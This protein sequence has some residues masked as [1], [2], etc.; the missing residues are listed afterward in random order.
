VQQPNIAPEVTLDVRVERSNGAD[1]LF[2]AGELDVFTAPILQREL[3]D[4]A[5]T[6]G[7]LILDLR[8]LTFMDGLGLR[9]LERAAEYAGREGWDLSIVNCPSAVRQVFEMA[10]IDHLLSETD[11]SDR[12]DPGNGELTPLPSLLR[13]RESRQPKDGQP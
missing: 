9:C 12:S 8:E 6:G 13:Q 10:G 11:T 3:D 2:L 7:V 1:R 4:V 5:Q